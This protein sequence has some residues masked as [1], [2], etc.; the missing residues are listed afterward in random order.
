M[1]RSQRKRDR[2]VPEHGTTYLVREGGLHQ[3]RERDAFGGE[4]QQQLQVG[5]DIR[6]QVAAEGVDAEGVLHHLLWGK[7]LG[8]DGRGQ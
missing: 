6:L 5:F 4:R 2:S 8:Y 7:G 1:Y 3:V